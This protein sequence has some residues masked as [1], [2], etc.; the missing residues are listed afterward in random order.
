MLSA[1]LRSGRP[2]PPAPCP[3]AHLG[4]R[5]GQVQARL[6][7]HGGQ[8]GV[9]P[10]LRAA[11]GGQVGGQ[12]ASWGLLALWLGLCSTT[13]ATGSCHSLRLHP[14]PHG[15]PAACEPPPCPPTFSRICSTSSGVMGPTYLR[16]TQ[17]A[18]GQGPQSMREQGRAAGEAA[19]AAS[20]RACGARQQRQPCMPR[21]AEG[22]QQRASPGRRGRARARAVGGAGVCH[23]GGGVGVDQD[24]LVAL[25]PAQQ[26]ARQAGWG[27]R[28]R[29]GDGGTGARDRRG[30]TNV[31]HPRL[32]A[33]PRT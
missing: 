30:T 1:G 10:L 29:L 28:R 17:H 4:Q 13:R 24:D 21:S 25:R 19:G 16:G 2:K 9:W 33:G 18:G 7:A 15:A 26:G 22:R 32:R 6:A 27:S 5:L 3:P 20:R 8:D 31:R 12:A 23:D 11:R 14:L